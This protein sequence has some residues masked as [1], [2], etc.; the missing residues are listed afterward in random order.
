MYKLE[1]ASTEVAAAMLGGH[2]LPFHHRSSSIPNT[3]ML[4]TALTAIIAAT[5]SMISKLTINQAL[6]GSV[7][8]SYTLWVDARHAT[9]PP[10]SII[11]LY[12]G[13]VWGCHRHHHR[14]HH[15]LLHQQHKWDNKWR[16]CLGLN[17]KTQH[18]QQLT[19]T[20]HSSDFHPSK[21]YQSH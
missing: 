16:H 18:L 9:W 4:A 12:G 13:M 8:A 5:T 20:F 7:A 17:S 2:H 21:I 14:H 11:K 15:H 10:T 3:T 19:T 1:S 6:M